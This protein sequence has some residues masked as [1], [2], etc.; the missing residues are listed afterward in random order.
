[1]NGNQ[2]ISPEIKSPV[3]GNHGGRPGFVRRKLGLT[4]VLSDPFKVPVAQASA[5]QT[6]LEADCAKK[7]KKNPFKAGTASRAV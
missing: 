6:A 4:F 1:M 7:V 2:N 5:A 3:N